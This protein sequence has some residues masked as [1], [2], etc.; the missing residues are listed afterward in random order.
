VDFF[1]LTT[2]LDLGS[3]TLS[4]GIATLTTSLGSLGSHVIS[5]NYFSA[6]PNFAPPAPATLTQQVQSEA[7]EGGILF[8]GGTTSGNSIQV[9]L[10]SSNYVVVNLNNGSSPAYQT[11]LAGL[12]ALVVYDQGNGANIQVNNNVRLP[13]Y[14]FAGNGRNTQIQG[15]GGPTV[16]VGGSGGGTLRG[17][18]GRNIL[19]AGSGGAQLQGGTGGSILIGGFTDY[20][21]NLAALEKALMEWNSS[22]SYSTRLSSAALSIFTASTVHSDG[23]ADQLQGGG[24]TAAL[25]WYFASSLDQVTGRNSND[26]TVTIH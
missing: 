18:S 6:S 7:I 3:V 9:T 5:A 11:P 22:D 16:E 14:L 2:D 1:D 8:V 24:G 25:D 4:G 17:G 21:S 23:H 19:I 20:D 10:N 26:V 12:T 15:G 13:A